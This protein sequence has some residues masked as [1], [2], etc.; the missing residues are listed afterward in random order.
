MI[1]RSRLPGADQTSR[2]E[3]TPI[4]HTGV[5]PSGATAS[6][7]QLSATFIRQGQ[8]PLDQDHL[9]LAQKK[10]T[11]N[12]KSIFCTEMRSVRNQASNLKGT[13]V[14]TSVACG[15]LQING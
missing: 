13:V 12:N 8:M 9:D 5:L 15:S 7:G 11:N 2:K 3:G 10:K 4:L 1:E 6:N 14:T